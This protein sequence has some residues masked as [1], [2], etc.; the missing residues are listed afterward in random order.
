[1]QGGFFNQQ[2]FWSVILALFAF[3]I[4]AMLIRRLI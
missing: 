3:G 4:I 1:V 2:T